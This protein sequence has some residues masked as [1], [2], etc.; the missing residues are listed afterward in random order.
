MLAVEVL[1]HELYAGSGLVAADPTEL[2]VLGGTL[3]DKV[4]LGVV[5]DAL[6][7]RGPRVRLGHLF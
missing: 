3:E 5:L 1:L 2:E 6:A 7:I 4:P